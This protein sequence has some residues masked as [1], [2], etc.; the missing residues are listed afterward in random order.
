VG[1]K[2]KVFL[3]VSGVSYYRLRVKY[4]PD[5]NTTDGVKPPIVYSVLRESSLGEWIEE[6]ELVVRVKNESQNTRPKNRQF[7]GSLLRD[8]LEDLFQA[9]VPVTFLD[10]YRYGKHGMLAT[11]PLGYTSHSVK[12]VEFEDQIEKLA[13]GSARIVLR[14]LPTTT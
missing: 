3:A 9:R 11:T 4:E 1:V 10:G 12:L 13:E 6:W 8:N 14:A 2:G 7:S 5:N